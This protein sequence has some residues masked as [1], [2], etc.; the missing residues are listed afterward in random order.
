MKMMTTMNNY[1]D[2]MV[3]KVTIKM[4]GLMTI[5]MM[6]SDADHNDDDG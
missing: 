4:M 1:S 6:M 2:D 3:V 5:M